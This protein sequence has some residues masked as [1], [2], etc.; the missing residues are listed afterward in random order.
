MTV[1]PF[2]WKLMVL[3]SFVVSTMKVALRAPL[4]YRNWIYFL[5]SRFSDREGIL[6][7][8]NGL[9]FWIRPHSTDRAAITEVVVLGSY[10]EV[11]PGAIVLD[12]G[13]NIGAF[14]LAASRR[15]AVV[16]ALEPVGENFELLRRNIELNKAGNIVAERVA[17]A[18]ENGECE[19]TIAGVFSS[20]HFRGAGAKVEKVPAITL[21][22]FLNERGIRELDYLKMDCEGAEWDI[23]LKAPPEVLARIKHIEMEFHN[24]GTKTHPRMLEEHLSSAGFTSTYSAG[25]RFNGGLVATR[26]AV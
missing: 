18:G 5:W 25:E 7:L 11:P 20:M 8:R 14:S 6:I 26:Q 4:V 9:R 2:R 3:G 19:M 1:S 16:Y 22:S 12:V 21:E 15:A 10:S 23:L 24:I 17:M 13:A